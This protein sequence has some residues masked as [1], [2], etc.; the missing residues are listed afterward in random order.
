[1][2]HSSWGKP[3]LTKSDLY[4]VMGVAGL[5]IYVNSKVGLIHQDLANN[6][7]NLS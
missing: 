7:K 3:G 2:T 5:P 4:R 6:L 1:M